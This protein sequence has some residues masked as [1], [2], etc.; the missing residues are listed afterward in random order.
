MSK[1]KGLSAKNIALISIFSALWIVLNL[2]VARIA[3]Q[4]LRLPLV[5]S[6][7]VFLIL[8]LIVWVTNQ[9]GISSFV[10]IIGSIIVLLAGGPL[11]VIGFA[12][13]S[14]LFDALLLVN[15]HK[16]NLKPLSIAVTILAAAVSS[17]FAGVLN[18]VFILNQQLIFAVT[19]WA[20][21]TIV[22]G[23]IGVA[24]ALPIIGVL[25][26]ANVKKLK[27]S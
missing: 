11:P 20:G 25:E 2:T 4:L 3:F 27:T 1:R 22:G 18:G 17:Y 5:H 19:F 9:Y 12:F 21:W 6:I 15:H 8:L 24:V 14:L 7:I 13:A 16:L 26:R 23:I 10:G